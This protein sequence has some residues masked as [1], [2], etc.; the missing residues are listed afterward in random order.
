[1]F[2]TGKVETAR[3]GGRPE[4]RKWRAAT[5][6]NR[7]KRAQKRHGGRASTKQPAAT[8]PRPV[9]PHQNL[10]ASPVE[11]V[12]NSPSHMT[13]RPRTKVPTGQPVTVLPS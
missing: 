1:M 6:W 11:G 3:P 12:V 2:D 5:L 10:S 7:A 13:R 9:P 8:R 4:T